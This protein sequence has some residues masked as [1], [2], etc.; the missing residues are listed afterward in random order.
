M[1]KQAVKVKRAKVVKIAKKQVVGIDQSKSTFDV[2]FQVKYEDDSMSILGT[3]KFSNDAKG[4]NLFLSWVKRK[5]LTDISLLFVVEATG[6]Y[7]ENLSYFIHNHNFKVSVVLPLKAKYYKQSLNIISKNDAIDAQCL[8]R[9]GLEHQLTLWQPMSPL[10]KDLRVLTR[11]YA[12][13]KKDLVRAKN[14]KHALVYSNECSQDAMSVKQEQIDFLDK[15]KSKIQKLIISYAKKDIEFYGRVK[16]IEKVKGLGYDTI[17]TLLAETNGFELFTSVSQVVSYS[18]L[19]IID[20]QSGDVTKRSRVSKRGNA[21]IR[22]CLYMPAMSSTNHNPTMIAY[23]ERMQ[24]SQII[25]RKALVPVMR[26]LLVLVYTLWKSGEDYNPNYESDKLCKKN[27][28]QV[29]EKELELEKIV[30]I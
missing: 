18:G 23:F 17:I 26:K 3:S 25:Y 30:Q 11:E 20:N 22:A 4:F 12:Q 15:H 6:V 7:Y 27:S 19:D 5:M 14:Q 29:K 1:K 16:K 13:I 8:S 28:D 24:E 9:M 2:C 21:Q 10:F